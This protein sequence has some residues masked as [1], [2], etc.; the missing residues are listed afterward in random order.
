LT[1]AR[2]V[3]LLNGG[4]VGPGRELSTDEDAGGEVN[5]ALEGFALEFA[6]ERG[7]RHDCALW[8]RRITIRGHFPGLVAVKYQLG[9]PGR[10][11]SIQ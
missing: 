6:T 10:K 1:R 9:R 11:T 3:C 4:L 8:S 5:L 2:S 7:C